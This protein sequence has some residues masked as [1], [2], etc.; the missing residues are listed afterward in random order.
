[1][2]ANTALVEPF[3]G[4]IGVTKT[5]VPSSKSAASSST[6]VPPLTI[7]LYAVLPMLIRFT[8]GPNLVERSNSLPP[9]SL[10]TIPKVR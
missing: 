9:I 7:A 1:M 5:A 4:A 6:T 2:A 10:M 3:G 8:F